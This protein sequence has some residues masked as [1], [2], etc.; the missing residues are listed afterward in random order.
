M[1]APSDSGIRLHSLQAI[2][3]ESSGHANLVSGGIDLF[4]N[5]P[6]AGWGSG[7][8]SKAYLAQQ[9]SGTPA[10]V[11]ASHTTPVT[12]AAE[13]GVIGLIVYLLVVVAAFIR[14]LEGARL[15]TART[16]ITAGLAAL[17]VHSLFYA[18]FFEDPT[19]WV[20]LALAVALPV[21]LTREQRRAERESRR[22]GVADGPPAAGIAPAT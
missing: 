6:V 13:Q 20:I 4:A 22:S 9:K 17:I 15:S 21:P 7:S 16:A 10:A 8:F 5:R 12:A 14:G 3:S 11:S 18:A 2:N 19:T 1:V